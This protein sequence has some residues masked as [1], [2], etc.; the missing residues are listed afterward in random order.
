MIIDRFARSC[1]R[2]PGFLLYSFYMT[3]LL[4]WINK[5][6]RGDSMAAH[7]HLLRFIRGVYRLMG[8]KVTFKGKLPDTP[9]VFMGNHRSYVDAILM[10]SK[11]PVSFVARSESQHWPIIGWGASL[12]G[13]IWVNR[14][15][16]DSRKAT[17]E[18]VK[19]RLESGQG[20]I[21]FPEGTTHIGPDVLEYRPSMFYICAEG[22]FPIT[23]VAIEYKDPSIAWVGNTWFIPHAWK[24]FGKP[25]IEVSVTFGET[26]TYLDGGLALNEVRE[27]TTKTVANLREV[28]DRS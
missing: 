17:R 4:M 26:K 23:P 10:P 8:I 11:F 9:S 28:Y 7:R 12:L 24:Q 5:R 22:G 3:L 16:P 2:I 13:T 18:R 6:H 27:W 1:F 21:I 19:Q 20:I 25:S 15:D 14:K